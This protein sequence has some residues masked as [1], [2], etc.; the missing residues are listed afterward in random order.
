MKN[1]IL[2]LVF[3]FSIFGISLASSTQSHLTNT[4]I[5][6]EKACKYGQCNAT[7]KSTGKR[8]L[9]CVSNSGDRNCWQHK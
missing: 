5:S 6:I 2:S 7:A 1:V 8:C 3:A 4:T 9:H